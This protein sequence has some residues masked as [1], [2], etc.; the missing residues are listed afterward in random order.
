MEARSPEVP[1][2]EPEPEPGC[3]AEPGRVLGV[4]E[5]RAGCAASYSA[6]LE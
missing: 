3:D 2:P 4:P 5:V 1:G 6:E